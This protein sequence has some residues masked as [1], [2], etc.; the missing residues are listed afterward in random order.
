MLKPIS[1]LLNSDQR[2]DAVVVTEP[3][4]VV[5]PMSQVDLHA[6]VA[7]LEL[8]DTVPAG[9]RDEF[10]VGRNAFVYSWFCYEFTTLAERHSFA[11]LELA[12]RLRLD[13]APP[14]TT[15]SPG[16]RKLLKSAV[17]NGYLKREKYSAPPSFGG[18]CVCI[19]DAIPMLR[20]HLSHGNP[21]LLPQGSI[22]SMRLCREVICDLFE[23]KS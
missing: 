8:P 4:G 17:V 2:F 1:A 7:P 15:R 13:A 10:D 23:S 19:L 21:H 9:V 14:G 16:L 6:M 11:T 18:E 12:L 3:S 22:E 5:R 20:D